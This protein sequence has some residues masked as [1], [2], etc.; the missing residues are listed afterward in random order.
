MWVLGIETAAERGGVALLAEDGR[1]YELV[2]DAGRI[3]AEVLAVAAEGLV[4]TVGINRAEIAAL[5]VDVGPG[6][7]TGIRIGMSFAA[8]V[9]QVL[10]VPTV[11][12]RQSE[13][14]GLPAAKDWPG[15]VLVLIHDRGKHVYTAWVIRGK[16]GPEVP[17][18]VERALAK[19]SGRA[20]VLVVGSGVTNFR[21]ALARL[22]PEVVAGLGY[23]YASPLA[24]ARQ[25]LAAWNEGGGV[26]AGELEP[27]YIHPPVG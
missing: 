4:Q 15:R 16:V 22:A 20:G 7:F 14:V 17:T 5:A 24:V 19:L 1:G 21:D 2:F 3:H 26:P 10:G 8:G 18:T 25:G 27:C 6:S 12:I 23:S 13:A 11:G 9:A